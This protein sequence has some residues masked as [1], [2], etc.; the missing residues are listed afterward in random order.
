MTQRLLL[1]I[2]TLSIHIIHDCHV[3][4]RWDGWDLIIDTVYSWDKN[5]LSVLYLSK[6]HHTQ[7]ILTFNSP[8]QD[9]FLSLLISCF[10]P[11]APLDTGEIFSKVVKSLHLIIPFYYLF[12]FLTIDFRTCIHILYC[13]TKICTF[14]DG[15]DNFYQW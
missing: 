4:Q 10:V 8:Q 6:L 12:P 13:F 14:I 2:R 3:I 5:S 11:L 7:L 15:L 1:P 9:L